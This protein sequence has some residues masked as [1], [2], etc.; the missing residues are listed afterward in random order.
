MSRLTAIYH[1]RDDASRVQARANGIAVEQSVEMPVAAITDKTVLDEIV[2]RVDDIRDLGNGTFE[3]RIGRPAVEGHRV[4][5]D[6]FDLTWKQLGLHDKPIFICDVA[7]SAAPLL[8]MI[9]ATIE[10][11]FAKPDVRK[12]YEPVSGVAALL[13]RLARK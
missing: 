5:P 4:R 3:A 7:G 11:G 9:E 6:G 10:M 8:R 12:M 1:I 2:G 13:E